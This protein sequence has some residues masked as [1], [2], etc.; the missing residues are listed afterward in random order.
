MQPDLFTR[1]PRFEGPDLGPS[2]Q[3]RLTAQQQRIVECLADG[4]WYTLHEISVESGAP[5]ASASAQLRHLR[6][7]RFGSHTVERRHVGHGLYEYRL[8]R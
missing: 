1:A 6:K 8:A 7:P 3:V 4:R 2:D 5:E